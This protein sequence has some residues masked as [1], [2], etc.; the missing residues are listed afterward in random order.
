M[1][2]YLS[3]EETASLVKALIELV[4]KTRSHQPK[5]V[6]SLKH[7]PEIL[8]PGRGPDDALPDLMVLH[9]NELEW[10]F[11][12]R[13]ETERML[14]RETLED[15]QRWCRIM[16]SFCALYNGVDLKCARIF[17][18]FQIHLAFTAKN[19]YEPN[20]FKFGLLDAYCALTA[21]NKNIAK[22]EQDWTLDLNYLQT[23]V[24]CQEQEL[25]AELSAV[26]SISENA[27]IAV[28]HPLDHDGN[29]QSTRDKAVQRASANTRKRSRGTEGG[30]LGSD[31]KE[32]RGSSKKR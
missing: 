15:R 19:E 16:K 24:D 7:Y 5:V 27:E 25:E 32:P 21:R 17:T 12:H 11:E 20:L 22:K 29:Q 1:N 18:M 4:S 9:K 2:N 28:N 30:N 14:S 6:M 26:L 31:G 3:P 8:V 13:W 23:W 10:C